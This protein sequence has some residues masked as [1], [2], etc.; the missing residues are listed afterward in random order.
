MG[1]SGE[2]QGWLQR[3]CSPERT[4]II[5]ER[6]A[7][8]ADRTGRLGSQPAQRKDLLLTKTTRKTAERVIFS[9]TSF[10]LFEAKPRRP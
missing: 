1:D 3:E 5:G 7:N 9:R 6:S 10:S 8:G 2:R 4:G